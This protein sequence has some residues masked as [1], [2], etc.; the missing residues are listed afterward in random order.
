MGLQMSAVKTTALVGGVLVTTDAAMSLIAGMPSPVL[1]MFI[2][3]PSAFMAT[4]QAMMGL[5]M[6]A[7]AI[8]EVFTKSAPE[9]V[10]PK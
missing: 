6:S 4:F 9:N 5:G 8:V 1:R 10:D 2:A 7:P 3:N